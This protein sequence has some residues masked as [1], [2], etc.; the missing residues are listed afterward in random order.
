MQGYP[1]PTRLDPNQSG[2]SV[3]LNMTVVL[4]LSGLLLGRWF[5]IAET[6]RLLARHWRKDVRIHS[7]IFTTGVAMRS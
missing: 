1:G 6:N 7:V 3:G 4:T 2:T 5:T